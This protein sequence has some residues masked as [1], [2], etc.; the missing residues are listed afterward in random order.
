MTRKL[1]VPGVLVLIALA[2]YFPLRKQA[3]YAKIVTELSRI[4]GFLVPIEGSVHEA[5]LAAAARGANVRD[6]DLRPRFV[7]ASA[8]LGERELVV[9]PA[10]TEAHAGPDLL[11]LRAGHLPALGGR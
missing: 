11:H 3:R 10:F 4:D 8:R 2:A 5:L 7:Y 9:R 1:G 6:L